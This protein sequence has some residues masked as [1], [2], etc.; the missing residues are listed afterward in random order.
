MQNAFTVLSACEKI[1]QISGNGCF[2]NHEKCFMSCLEYTTKRK[3]GRSKV[4]PKC[5]KYPVLIMTYICHCQVIKIAWI[6]RIKQYLEGEWLDQLYLCW[7]TY[8]Y[9]YIG[10]THLT[11]VYCNPWAHSYI[12]NFHYSFSTTV[13]QI[14]FFS[15]LYLWWVLVLFTLTFSSIGPQF[16]VWLNLTL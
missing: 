9:T 14:E 2:L 4:L 6:F 16:L 11:T 10:N 13:L 8:S 3:G 1:T 12:I 15:I 5:H 7:C